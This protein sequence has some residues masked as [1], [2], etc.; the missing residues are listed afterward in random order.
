LGDEVRAELRHVRRVCFQP[1]P[2][3]LQLGG[4]LLLGRRLALLPLVV[5]APGRPPPA[6]FGPGRVHGDAVLQLD[7]L[8]AAP[9]ACARGPGREHLGAGA[10]LLR[11]AG[12]PV[13]L[14]GASCGD[15]GPRAGAAYVMAFSLFLQRC[16]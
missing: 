15:L 2:D 4:Q 16:R 10:D 12:D 6:P 7:D 8:A 9:G 3:L 1:D 13:A 5:L 14:P 11:L